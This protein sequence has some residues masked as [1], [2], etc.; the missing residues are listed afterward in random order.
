MHKTNLTSEKIRLLIRLLIPI[1]ITQC[2]M[3]AMSF[4]DTVMSGH[5]S[6]DD[7][8]GVAI[9]SNI[10][11]PIFTGLSGILMG[12]TPIISH[13]IGAKEEH[14]IGSKLVQALYL[15]IGMALIVI[16]IGSF[17]LNPL[18]HLMNLTPKVHL[19]ARHY[20]IALSFGMVPLFGYNVLRGF[21]DAHGLTRLSMAITLLAPPVNVIFNYFFIFGKLGFPKLGGVGAGVATAIT[22][23]I[24]MLVALL[25][26]AKGPFF[27]HYKL[28][29]HWPK[30]E[31]SVWK[32]L[33]K[34]GLP[35]GFSI[36]F[37]T[38]I[39]AVSTILMSQYSTIVVAA[40]Q[41]ALNFAS[42]LY[43][44][45][46]SMS[47]TLT[48]AVGFESG[49]KRFRDARVYSFIGIG[50][51]VLFAG[52]FALVL[53]L[54]NHPVAGLYTTNPI[55]I[56]MTSHF[57]LYAIFFQFSDAFQAPIQGSL[58]GYKDVNITFIMTLISYWVIGLPVGILLSHLTALGPYGYWLGLIAG[59]A[60]GAVTLFIRLLLVQKRLSRQVNLV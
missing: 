21:I 27:S 31:F 43:M 30:I 18:L 4:F 2:G 32:E 11:M 14:L 59:L 9:G 22:Y 10:W 28:F 25:I 1:L 26:L 19:I 16:L 51:T 46:L 50:I 60:V 54:F 35:I 37:E 58:R 42:F 55:V 49:A 39:F 3:Y 53:I 36:F 12:L 57:L 13:H 41:A 7:L 33:L 8:A 20:L 48:I 45:P 24:I 6:A 44:L 23:W 5:A 38:S 29:R 40:H 34:I 52:F 17:V 47:M 15:A 56:K